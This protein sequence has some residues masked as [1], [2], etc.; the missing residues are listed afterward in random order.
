MNLPC[1]LSCRPLVAGALAVLACLSGCSHRPPLDAE[2]AVAV[3]HVQ[4]LGFTDVK[5]L[6]VTDGRHLLTGFFTCPLGPAALKPVCIEVRPP[7]LFQVVYDLRG[8]RLWLNGIAVSPQPLPAVP[9]E[10][11]RAFDVA[12]PQRAG[13]CCQRVAPAAGER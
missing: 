7:Q 13:V 1:L 11:R 10:L 12:D 3:A 5:H 2:A 4:A 8:S 9:P 6:G